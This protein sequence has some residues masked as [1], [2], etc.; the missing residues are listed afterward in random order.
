MHRQLFSAIFPLLP[1]VDGFEPLI[2]GSRVE[3]FHHFATTATH[4]RDPVPKQWLD[5]NPRP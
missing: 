5:L 1:S 3:F 2:L 4:A